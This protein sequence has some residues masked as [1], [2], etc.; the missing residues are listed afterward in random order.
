MFS[1]CSRMTHRSNQ[2]LASLSGRGATINPDGRFEAGQR[3]A[4][5]DGWGPP[6]DDAP[7]LKT[8]TFA[9]TSRTIIARNTS[10]DIGFD[11]SIN[12]YRGCEHGCI[13][14]YA[15]PSHNYLGL[16][17][18]Q[19]FESKIFVKHDAAN[20]LRQELARPGYRPAVLALGANTDPYQPIERRL[21]I[22]RGI[23]EVLLETRHPVTIVTKSAAIVRDI[24]LL[25]RLAGMG[26]VHVDISITSLDAGL[27]RRMEP[28]A[29]TP[30]RRFDAIRL[31]RR[32][33][34]EVGVNMAPVIPGLNDHE[35]E[36]MVARAVAAGAGHVN[37]ILVRLPHDVKELFEAWLETH[38]PDRAAR[39]LSLIRQC[40]DGRL[41]DPDF[42]SRMRGS[43][44]FAEL[45][46]RRFAV[47]IAKAG[48][49][50]RRYPDR[51]DLFRPPRLDGQ[52][53]LL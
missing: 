38:F 23:L 46:H 6:D 32:A 50:R 35:I 27:A 45:I 30:E 31:L 9:D 52:M 13:Y 28:R 36:A 20:L 39:V 41:N 18:G 22:T 42:K 10:P 51:V 40:R 5:D 53:S 43:G 24:D 49:T 12:P 16:S 29:P 8:E 11:R 44:P 33:G 3:Q 19:D 47:A 2:R 37:H 4:E 26:L 7:A 17:S 14:C 25:E 15:R 1:Y 34:V 21:R 48:L